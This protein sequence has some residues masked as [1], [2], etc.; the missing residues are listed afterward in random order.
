MR[1]RA[2]RDCGLPHR[3]RD[4][5][6]RK[7]PNRRPC[8]RTRS[9]CAGD[10]TTGRRNRILPLSQGPGEDTCRPRTSAGNAFD[11]SFGDAPCGSGLL[12]YADVHGLHQGPLGFRLSEPCP[13]NAAARNAHH[14]KRHAGGNRLQRCDSLLFVLPAEVHDQASHRPRTNGILAPRVTMVRLQGATWPPP[15]SRAW[16]A[17]KGARPSRPTSGRALSLIR[18][19]MGSGD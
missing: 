19:Q 18:L 7:L 2:H 13:R 15:A 10:R 14:D 8:P 3:E 9:G 1:Q 5:L 11:A 4:L 17:G 16:Q 6:L 12:R